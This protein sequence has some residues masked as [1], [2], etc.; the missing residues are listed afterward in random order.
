MLVITAALRGMKCAVTLRDVSLLLARLLWMY[1]TFV[2]LLLC[3]RDGIRLGPYQQRAAGA[4][5]RYHARETFSV[6]QLVGL[7]PFP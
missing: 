5:S 3:A 4:I 7:L 1:L 6:Q 2:V